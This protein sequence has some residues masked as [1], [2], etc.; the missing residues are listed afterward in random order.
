[1]ALEDLYAVYRK[2]WRP[3]Q[4]EIDR[5][6][7]RGIKLLC[8]E[9][10]DEGESQGKQV[11]QAEGDDDGEGWYYYEEGEEEE[12]LEEDA[13][14]DESQE[15]IADADLGRKLGI[16]EECLSPPSPDPPVPASASKS[17]SIVAPVGPAAPRQAVSDYLA[18]ACILEFP[19]V[20]SQTPAN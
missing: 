16:P 13:Y 19:F 15:C 10:Q 14:M 9:G 2:Q 17:E 8:V 6:K 5:A 12:A 20:T 1:M 11:V 7:A 4:E 3:T 18:D